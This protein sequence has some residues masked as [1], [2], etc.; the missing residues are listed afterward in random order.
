VAQPPPPPGGPP[1]PPPPPGAGSGGPSWSDT[2][3]RGGSHPPPGGAYPPPGGAT[4]AGGPVRG[5]TPGGS[6][7]GTGI[8]PVRALTVGDILDGAFR[9]LRARFARIALLVLVVLGPY[10]LLSSFLTARWLPGLGS[11]PQ[12]DTGEV[13]LLD[14]IAIGQALGLFTVTGVLGFAVHLWVA[15][16]LV[17]L[18]LQEDGGPAAGVGDA[19]R[20][21]LRRGWALVGGSMLVLGAGMVVA[22]VVVLVAVALGTL[23]LPL[24][25]VVGVPAVLVLLAAL[26]AATSLVVPVAIVEADA[27]AARAG[28][29]ALTL[30]WRRLPRMLGVTVLV[31][32]VL[33]AVT[34]AISLVLTVV[35]FVAGPLGWVV[36]G[37]SGTAISMVTTPVTMFA[38]LLLYV[39]ARVR[40]EAWDLELRA[41][42]PP[43]W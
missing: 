41:T 26:V 35:A 36:D 10:Q 1:P 8:L 22:T 34:M 21:S 12:P 29:R 11:F 40:L 24:A 6:P 19:L 37:I 23:A 20:A 39:D 38:A 18:V 4:S 16:A 31:L 14:D 7:S 30:L 42:P 15:G 5:P 27:G 17:W 13:M 2:R 33:L 3:R 9:L 25:F 43:T 28:T 32:L